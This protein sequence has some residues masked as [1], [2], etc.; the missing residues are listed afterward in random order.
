MNE[1]PTQRAIERLRRM[2]EAVRHA[3]LAPGA[4]QHDNRAPIGWWVLDESENA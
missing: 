2:K 3:Q 4:K 1:N